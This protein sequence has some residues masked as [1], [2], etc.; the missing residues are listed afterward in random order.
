[1]YPLYKD[2]LRLAHAAGQEPQWWDQN[3]TP[4]FDEF[5]PD[6]QGVYDN[7]ALLVEIE[8][9]SCAQR[10]LVAGGWT[11]YDLWANSHGSGPAENTLEDLADRFHYG[12][13]PHHDYVSKNYTGGCAGTTMNSIPRRIVEA[14]ERKKFDWERR[15]DLEGPI[16]PPDWEVEKP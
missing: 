12:D 3:G 1:M 11:R 9:Q 14:W 6:Q 8:C 2:I 13:A 5:A 7:F 4:R 10:F 15:E 16:D